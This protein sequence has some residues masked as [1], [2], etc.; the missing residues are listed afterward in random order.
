MQIMDKVEK[1]YLEN[2]DII[3]KGIWCAGL[4]GYG[5]YVG[6]LI[7]GTKFFEKG[8]KAGCDASEALMQMMEPEAY[9][10]M[11]KT[12]EAATKILMK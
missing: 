9:A 10:R 8:L 4:I 11:C 3:W 1:F 5:F 12:A 7:G 2:E 6:Y